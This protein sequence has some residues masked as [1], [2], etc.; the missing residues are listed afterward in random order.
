MKAS[1]EDINFLANAAGSGAGG[2]VLAIRLGWR[3]VGSKS[4]AWGLQ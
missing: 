4:T 1:D 3:D 2:R